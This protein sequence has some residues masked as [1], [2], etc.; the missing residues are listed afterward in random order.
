MS[1]NATFDTCH[2]HYHYHQYAAYRLYSADAG[3]ATTG[4]KQAFCA[5]D[6]D[7]YWSDAGPSKYDCQDQGVSVGWADTYGSG[8]DC[9]WIDIT[10]VAPGDYTLEVEANPARLIAEKDYANNIARVHVTIP[11]GGSVCF[12]RPEICGNGQDENCNG[13]ADDGCPAI[14]GNDTCATAADLGSGGEFTSEITASTVA[15]VTPTCGGS[16]GDIFFR[17]SLMAP[18]LVYLSTYGSTLDTVLTLYSGVCPGTE[19]ACANDGC[20]L[21]QSHLAQNLPAGEYTVAV[22]AAT[23]GATGTVKL[24]FQS[25][26]CNTAQALSGPATINGNTT[27][28]SDVLTSGCGAPGGRDD[29]YYLVSCPGQTTLTA[30]TCG[31]GFDTVLAVRQGS[32]RSV[33]AVCNNDS[34]GLQSSVSTSLNKPGLWFLSVDGINATQFGPYQLTVSY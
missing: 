14:V 11:D 20:G 1:P 15:D 21:P 26:I 29:L 22:K 25:S 2:G 19:A 5:L 23:A 17:F 8:L 4:R 24:S 10:D 7:R 18:Q 12:N 6:S 3:L 30:S 28:A 13:V 9:Q 34:C 32:C 16:G 33:D 27:N 31:T